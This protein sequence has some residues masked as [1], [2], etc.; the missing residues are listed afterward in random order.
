MNILNKNAST[1]RNIDYK[2]IQEV[3]LGKPVDFS[4]RG[5]RTLH[6]KKTDTMIN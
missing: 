5:I 6:S 1:R 3:K 2:L 4:F